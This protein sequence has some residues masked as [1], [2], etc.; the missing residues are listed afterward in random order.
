MEDIKKKIKKE[1]IDKDFIM[2]NKDSIKFLISIFSNDDYKD[3]YNDNLELFHKYIIWLKDNKFN[4]FNFKNRYSYDIL[5]ELLVLIKKDLYYDKKYNYISEL[6]IIEKFYNPKKIYDYNI[7]YLCNDFIY[8]IFI[9]FILLYFFIKFLCNFFINN[10][11]K[12]SKANPMYKFNLVLNLKDVLKSDES[13]SSN[14]L[15][16]LKSDEMSSSSSSSSS[17]SNFLDNFKSDELSSSL[18]N[19]LDNFKLDESSL[20]SSNFLDNFKL[21]ESSS[22]LSNFLDNNFI[23]DNLK[24]FNINGENNTIFFDNINNLIKK[25]I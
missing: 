4:K 7:N 19:F 18:S 6:D 25:I 24:L 12:N 20:S 2:W 5:V 10:Y 21:D 8:F 3:L 11:L 23:K 15:D 13:S 16:N 1:L 22:S 17:S 9:G 14:F